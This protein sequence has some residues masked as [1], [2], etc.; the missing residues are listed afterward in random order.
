METVPAGGLDAAARAAVRVLVERL[1]PDIG[2]LTF[3]ELMRLLTEAAGLAATAPGERTAAGEPVLFRAAPTLGFPAG[4]IAALRV[5]AAAEDWPAEAET[6]FLGLYG[7]SSPMPA[8][9]T[10]RVLFGDDDERQNL[11]DLLDLFGHALTGLLYRIWQRNR[12]HLGYD[13]SGTDAASHALHAMAG[14]GAERG[15]ES[16]AEGGAGVRLDPVRLLPLAGLLAQN[17]RSAAVIERV[18]GPYF[19]IAAR[20]EEW[21]ERRVVIP[22]EARFALGAP[23][24]AL[25][26]GLLLGAS[27]A[28]LGTTICLLLGPLDEATFLDFLPGGARRPELAALLR[29]AVREP[30]AIRVDLLLDP[31]ADAAFRLGGTRLGATSWSGA[32]AE[33][34]CTTGFI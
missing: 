7:P 22:P 23:Q 2:A 33:R 32:A 24:S 31:A 11:R 14:A 8:F 20:I 30:V 10:E 13:R 18:I 4:E 15:A 16:G 5:R 3:P 28:D 26:D 34:R 21:V 17:T 19:G 12:L 29:L 25:G 1:A 27:V 9:W 6:T